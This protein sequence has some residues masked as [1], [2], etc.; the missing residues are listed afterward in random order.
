MSCTNLYAIL[1]QEGDNP[2]GIFAMMTSLGMTPMVC[3]TEKV[4][5]IMLETTKGAIPPNTK[6]RLVRAEITETI[7]CLQD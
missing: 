5:R 4:A 6:V 1:T 7:E 2:E 3:A